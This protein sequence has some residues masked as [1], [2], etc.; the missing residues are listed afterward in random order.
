ML[1]KVKVKSLYIVTRVNKNK[2]TLTM[3]DVHSTYTRMSWATS[4]SLAWFSWLSFRY[5]LA[6]PSQKYKKRVL[7]KKLWIIRRTYTLFILN[8]HYFKLPLK[9]EVK[10]KDKH[11]SS[12]EYGFLSTTLT[13][14]WLGPKTLSC[15]CSNLT[16]KSLLTKVCICTFH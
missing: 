5:F 3:S 6:P 4:N 12:M 2:C 14:M 16:K 13:I 9:Y 1:N 11:R 10:I 7:W 8:T 15:M